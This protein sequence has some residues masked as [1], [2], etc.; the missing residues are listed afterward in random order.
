[1][2]V[3]ITQIFILV[4]LS[5][6]ACYAILCCLEYIVTRGR[7]HRPILFSLSVSFFINFTYI[8]ILFTINEKL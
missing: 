6:S 3:M 1:M 7:G 2:S 4:V 5:I 8:L